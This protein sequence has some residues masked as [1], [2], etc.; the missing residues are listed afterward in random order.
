MVATRTLSKSRDS[1][2]FHF[3]VGLVVK[4]SALRVADLG[5]NSSL[6]L[7]ISG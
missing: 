2:F 1:F 3:F 7:D 5:L 6:Y 4:A